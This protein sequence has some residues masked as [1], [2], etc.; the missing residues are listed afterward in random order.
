MLADDIK[1]IKGTL[2]ELRDFGLTVG[3]VLGGIGALAFWFGKPA[4]PWLLGVG[5]TLAAA[6]LL[7]P[8][9]LKQL[10]KAWMSMALVLGWFMTRVILGVLFYLVF[11][12]IRLLAR[13]MGKGFLDMRWRDGRESYWNVRETDEPDT[14]RYKKQF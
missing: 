3:G 8:S 10:Y 12:A 7:A 13:L 1:N 9:V 2:K 14:E 6:G 11:T 4:A 5:A